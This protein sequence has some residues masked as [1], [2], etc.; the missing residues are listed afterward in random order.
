MTTMS[1]Q[2]SMMIST[3]TEPKGHVYVAC[4]KGSRTLQF[5]SISAWALKPVFESLVHNRVDN[6]MIRGAVSRKVPRECPLHGIH[7]IPWKPI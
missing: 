6:A 2:R 5:G 4:P 3:T 7:E 1:H